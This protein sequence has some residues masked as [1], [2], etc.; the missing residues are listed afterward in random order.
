MDHQ[1]TISFLLQDLKTLKPH[2][3]QKAFSDTVF[4]LL[5]EQEALTVPQG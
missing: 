4:S 2:A 1:L 3:S 5:Q